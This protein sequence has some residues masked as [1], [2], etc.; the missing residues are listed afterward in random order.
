MKTITT[1][2]LI[3]GG[4]SAGIAAAYTASK[5]GFSV[6]LID[7]HSYLGGNATA[8]EVG[9]ICGLYHQNKSGIQQYIIKG[10]GRF[11]AEE[12]RK[13]GKSIPLSNKDGLHYLPYSIQNFKDLA[14]QL[15]TEANVNCLFSTK[16]VDIEI[17]NKQAKSC[18]VNQLDE[19]VEIRFQSIIDCSGKS[20]VSKLANL[21]Y[22]PSTK[23][24]SAALVFAMKQVY[25]ESENNINFII[26]KHL[27]QAIERGDLSEDFKKL[28]IVPGSL[29]GGEIRFKMGI[30]LEVTLT[31]NNLAELKRKGTEMIYE[32]IRFLVNEI[33]GFAEAELL[34]IADDVGIRTDY[35]SQGHYVLTE[36]DVLSCRKFDNAI[37][38][39]SWPIEEWGNELRVKMAY[40]P[41]NDYYQI[42]SECLS[43]LHVQ[44]L[45]FGGKNVSATDRAIA[46][47]RV[48]G[49]CFQTGEAAGELAVNYI[50]AKQSTYTLA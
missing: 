26:I 34:Y 38:N 21:P 25:F 18:I 13:M 20:I 2:I 37:A 29:Q 30:P 9:T 7:N 8:S 10:F 39:C 40:L 4:G 3:I 41:D 27:H 35:R 12:L 42:P 44:N 5:N 22:I 23:F 46:S 36:E 45:F 24:Q 47:A 28:F 6:T 19:V 43:S 1:D 48:M 14:N 32:I 31:K 11:F 16:I 50:K 49:I 33:D 17:S 15:M